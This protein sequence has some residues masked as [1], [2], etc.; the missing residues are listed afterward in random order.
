LALDLSVS[1]FLG[2]NI[3]YFEELL[4][5]PI[6]DL[7]HYQPHYIISV[8]LIYETLYRIGIGSICF[9]FPWR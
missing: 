9:C 1:A 4:P 7:R 8:P 3:K 5:H 2:D 6:E